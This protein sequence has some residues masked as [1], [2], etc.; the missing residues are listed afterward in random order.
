[1]SESA[2][3]LL[4]LVV[5]DNDSNLD[6]TV[7]MLELIGCK[8]DQAKD[9]HQAVAAVDKAK[10]DIIFMDCHLPVMD[11]FEATKRIRET[12]KGTDR[13][14]P[15]IAFTADAMPYQEEKCRRAGMDDF[16]SKPV[17]YE[18]FERMVALYTDHL[19]Q[20]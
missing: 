14:T 8:V 4:A 18:D 10:Y 15:I 13:R 2:H 9:G 19:K 12:E 1:M 5:E 6:V 16:L 17:S 11:G 20:P 3:E 7:K